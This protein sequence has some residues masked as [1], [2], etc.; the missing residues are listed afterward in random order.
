MTTK[1]MFDKGLRCKG[2]GFNCNGCK[3][4]DSCEEYV[5]VDPK[6]LEPIS[7]KEDLNYKYP[8]T[9][10]PKKFCYEIYYE[11]ILYGLGTFEYMEE[12][13]STLTLYHDTKLYFESMSKQE[14]I[15]DN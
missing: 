8:I 13:V 6:I 3:E 14:E 7:L 5:E 10:I 12:C 2:R 11:D 1:E 9:I 15:E 4:K